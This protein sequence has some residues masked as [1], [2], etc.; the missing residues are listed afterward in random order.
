MIQDLRAEI[1][2]KYTSPSTADSLSPITIVSNASSDS[3]YHP[4][5]KCW[6]K[7]TGHQDGATFQ[8]WMGGSIKNL[9]GVLQTSRQNNDSNT[10]R[11][12]IELIHNL[13]KINNSLNYV[14]YSKVPPTS[15]SFVTAKADS[16]ASKHYIRPNDM[17][18]LTDI[19]QTNKQSVYLFAKHGHDP[20]DTY[21]QA[22]IQQTVIKSSN[23]SKYFTKFIKRFIN[24]T[25]A[26]MRW[27]L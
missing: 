21:G 26:I 20:N 1:H 23:Y 16:G 10:W 11:R 19:E 17:A 22:P 5:V 15:K 27:R 4:G 9:R 8:N 2:S 3:C 12:G 7:A 24:L 25:R 6:N 18:C 14:K 13:N